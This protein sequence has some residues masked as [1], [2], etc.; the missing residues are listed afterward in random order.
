MPAMTR[1]A[2]FRPTD[3]LSQIL[4]DLACPGCGYRDPG[5][6]YAH[7]TDNKLRVFCDGCGAFITITLSTE[8]VAVIRRR[9]GT[10]VSAA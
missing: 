6:A 8:Q 3:T 9:T 1:A 7:I 5:N 10:P 4:D 2:T